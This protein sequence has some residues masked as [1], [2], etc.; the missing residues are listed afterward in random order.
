MAPSLEP[1]KEVTNG[2]QSRPVAKS[3]GA[4]AS[5]PGSTL[6]LESA[7]KHDLVLAIF[8]AYIADLC[9]QF[10]GGH[11]G[12]AMGMAAIGIALYKY[13]LRY[14]PKNCDYF[15][16]DRFVLSNGM[17]PLPYVYLVKHT[18]T[19][20]CRT[21]GHACVWQY[22]FMHLIGIK[23]MTAEQVKSYHSSRFDSI[24]PGHPEIENEGI[25]VTTG[26]LGQGVANAVGLAMA[27]KNLAATYNRDGL[28][29]VNNMTYV[30]IG[31]ACLQEGVGLEAV[32][33]A[34]HWKLNNLCIIYDNNSITCDG[35][36]DIVSSEDITRKCELLALE[37]SISSMEIRTWARLWN[38]F[39]R[40]ELA[41]SRRSSTSGPLS[42]S[43]L[44]ELVMRRFTGPH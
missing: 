6:K 30:M 28:E 23:S 19:P 32:S 21:T 29:V 41:T 9:E 3:S 36:V 25:E 33:L 2:G 34:G 35:P 43:V 10:K 15:N 4:I 39:S 12:S 13:V 40:R 17:P 42:A 31:D 27:T 38:P 8:R 44:C 37:W 5:D 26:P 18:L 1:P 16:R 7:E 20:N 24:C 14:S 22:L 11:P